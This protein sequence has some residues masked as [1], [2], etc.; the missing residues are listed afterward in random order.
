MANLKDLKV[1]R[2]DNHEEIPIKEIDSKMPLHQLVKTMIDND[3]LPR[4][5]DAER[6]AGSKYQIIKDNRPLDEKLTLEE[7]GIKDGDSF[8]VASKTGGM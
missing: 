6:R 7:A 8:Y 3:K 4:F 1:L 5:T 2:M